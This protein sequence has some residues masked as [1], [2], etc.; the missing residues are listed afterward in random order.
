MKPRNRLLRAVL[1]LAAA[2]VFAF[3]LTPDDSHGGE[4]PAAP[5]PDTPPAPEGFALDGDLEHGRELFVKHCAV[6]HGERGEADGK[7]SPHLKPPP[8]NL[9]E[10]VGE[11]S[12]WELF[13]VVRD[14]GQ[15]VGRS[16]VMVGFGERL[17]EQALVDVASFARSLEKSE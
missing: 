11:R 4:S 1:A 5:S 9:P 10:R 15:A 6:C 14:G 7:L 13:L 2:G 17:D 12:D 8:G 3:L 16:P